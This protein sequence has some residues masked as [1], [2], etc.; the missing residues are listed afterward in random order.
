MRWQDIEVAVRELAEAV[1][2]VPCHPETIAGVKV[3]AVLRIRPDYLVLIE[4]SK[5]DDLDKLRED[6]AKFAV[7]KTAMMAQGIY[8][9]CYFVTSGDESSL[10]ASGDAVNVGVFSLGS[11][12][13]KFVGSKQYLFARAS[14][15][16]G[17]AVNPDTGESDTAK[18]TPISY[19]DSDGTK[20]GVRELAEALIDGQRFILLGE[21]GTGKSRCIKEVFDS[22]SET[23]DVFVPVAINLR[24]NWGYKRFSH[25]IRNHL[26]D[27]GLSQFCDSLVRSLR[28]G[29]H[30]LLL[31]GFDE[32]GS[33]SWSGEAARLG[34]IRKQSLA[35]V[36]ELLE[37]C[38]KSGVMI[39]GREHY[40][41]SD[42][43]MLDC[44]GLDVGVKILRCPEEFSDSEV[45]DYLQSNT[46]IVSIPDWMPR[47]PLIC[48]LLAKLTG[49]E[50]EQLQASATGEV[51]F[52][53]SVFDAIAK[54]ETRIN[55]AVDSETV[56]AVL[57]AL[58]QK[59]RNKPEA[60]ET[61]SATEIN[62]AFFSATGYAPIDESAILLQRLPYLGR[63]GSGGADRIFID[64]YAKDGLRGIA[65]GW[66]A[67]E[68]NKEVAREKWLQPLGA[69]GLRCLAKTAPTND[70]L[71]KYAR[72]ALAHGNP[73]V[74][75]DY[76][77]MKSTGDDALKDYGSLQ[78][79]GGVFD[80][81]Y[82]ISSKARSLTLTSC[83]IKR[84][85]VEDAEFESVWV[86]NSLI[87]KVDGV[88]SAAKMPE[89]FSSDCEFGSFTPAVT[90][91]RISELRLSNGQK[92]LLAITKKLFFQPG[93]GRQE[94]ALLRGA[95][96]YWD[97]A[98][99]DRV[100]R[101]MVAEGLVE[102][103]RGDHGALYRPKR[104]YTTRMARVLEMQSNC[105][106]PIWTL[107]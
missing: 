101:Y 98:A 91:S 4:I 100:I 1:W 40:F 13:S 34:A 12:A 9:E 72:Y 67:I 96:A 20:Y 99:A 24:D 17:S 16:F 44:L 84:L 23:Q 104:R 41:S 80:A 63:V 55:S 14:R 48:Q 102:R 69:F 60:N 31:D 57:L 50:L 71:E 62:D 45:K 32:I 28:I 89:V 5:R 29:R 27:L 37:N 6:L 97:T 64:G 86:S 73:V 38:S 76:V 107:A 58:S 11:F 46:D 92:T 70:T 94:E 83:I 35:G 106:D 2:A 65:L 25:I 78:I 93:A 18:Y 61:I 59:T 66:A 36:R 53:E 22:I 15:P 75:C 33:Q 19:I 56:K 74:A 42:Q 105:G 87:D 39:T 43:E 79:D 103:A 82:F 81:L 49:A 90:T 26:D 88:G 8:A 3:D 68:T 10:V 47:K 30:V 7:C 77:S 51:D 21:F 52:F 85:V 95:E 54:R